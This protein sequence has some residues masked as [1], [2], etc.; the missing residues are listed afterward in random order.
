VSDIHAREW[1]RGCALQGNYDPDL[2]H[3]SDAEIR[4]GVRAKVHQFG[5]YGWVANSGGGMLP[6][7]RPEGVAAFV[8]EI[9][10]YTSALRTTII[11][12]AVENSLNTKIGELISCYY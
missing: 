8:D 7:H 12:G 10:R 5:L 1:S 6:S 2:L 4:A 3:H 11:D 9:H